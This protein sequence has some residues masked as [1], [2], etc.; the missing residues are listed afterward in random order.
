MEMTMKQL[1]ELLARALDAM[2]DEGLTVITKDDRLFKPWLPESYWADQAKQ[3]IAEAN[4]VR[5]EK[6]EAHVRAMAAVTV[7]DV[8]EEGVPKLLG[9]DDR[10]RGWLTANRG[11]VK[12]RYRGNPQP[13]YTHECW[14]CGRPLASQDLR[15]V[16][17][18]GR[19]LC[20]HALLDQEAIDR[21]DYWTD[22]QPAPVEGE[23]EDG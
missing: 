11:M 12:Q 7:A 22:H 3:L 16:D 6:Q 13:S 10:F 5:R 4:V 20:D 23:Q 1:N 19:T 2:R 14:Q 21:E 18:S 9:H 15:W 17:H 8:L